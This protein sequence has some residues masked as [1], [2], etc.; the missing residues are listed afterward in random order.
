[1]G[2]PALEPYLSRPLAP[3]D[4]AVLAAIDGGPI[5]PDRALPAEP[6]AEHRPP[7]RER[8]VDR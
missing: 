5:E 1:M 3:P 2:D 8:V 7:P 4:P 6:F